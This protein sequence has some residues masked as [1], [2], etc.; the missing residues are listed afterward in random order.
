MAWDDRGD[1]PIS[2]TWVHVVPSNSKVS[3]LW[4]RPCHPP[5]YTV[6]FRALS[7]AIA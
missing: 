5:K 4:R 6:T 7:Y 1:G 3:E 2:L